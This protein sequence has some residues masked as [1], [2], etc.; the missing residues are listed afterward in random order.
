MESV[1][2]CGIITAWVRSDRDRRLCCQALIILH[3][4]LFTE[5]RTCTEELSGSTGLVESFNITLLCYR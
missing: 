1:R 3:D 5:V 2:K 4:V